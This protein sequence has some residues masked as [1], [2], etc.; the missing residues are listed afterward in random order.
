MTRDPARL[1]EQAV[2]CREMS[3]KR[4]VHLYLTAL[5]E[6]LDAEAVEIEDRMA[7]QTPQRPSTPK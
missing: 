3:A 1:R 6:R 7:M 5:A 4:G 2:L